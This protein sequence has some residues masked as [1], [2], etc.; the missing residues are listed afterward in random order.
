VSL[1][2]NL[3]PRQIEIDFSVEPL[4]HFEIQGRL[5]NQLFCLSDAHQLGSFFNRRV[6][7][8][9]SS[10]TAQYGKPDW[11][12]YAV[13][14]KWAEVSTSPVMHLESTGYSKVNVGSVDARNYPPNS[15]FF[16]FTPSVHNVNDSGLFKRGVF[17][18]EN[19]KQTGVGK[20]QIALC[21]RR[22]DYHQNPH[23]GIL[24]ANYYKKALMKI[25]KSNEEGEII[26]FCDSREETESFLET[27]G[28]PFDGFDTQLNALEA[29]RNLS[30]SNI[31]VMANSTF[32]F[33]GSFF[34][35]GDTYFP[36]PFYLSNPKWGSQLISDSDVIQFSRFP[37]ARYFL[38][39]LL[40]KAGI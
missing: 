30:Q 9:V 32:S 18:F 25:E 11:L 2:D 14:W 29:L 12:E 15:H 6:L 26:V 34:S 10:V 36:K 7:L 13:D 38:Q 1:L 23:L 31:I 33:W 5:G 39:L 35:K 28:I 21:V 40:L 16:G 4:L 20:N 8:D 24:P 3:N 22:G 19:K 37:R 27:N 17:P